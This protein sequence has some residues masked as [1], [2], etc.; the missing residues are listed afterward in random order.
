[1]GNDSLTPS[2]EQGVATHERYVR[3][4]QADHSF[5]DQLEGMPML[6][7]LS[8]AEERARMLAGQSAELAD[9]PVT[10]QRFQ[11]S[12]C[13]VYLIRPHHAPASAP[14]LFFLHGGGWVLGD[15]QT[16]TQLVC[17][18][19][20][21][22]QSVVAFVDYPRA[23]EHPYPVPLESCMSAVREVLQVA[24]KLQL[25]AERF[26]VVGDSSGGNLAA[27]L[28][29]AAIE[30]KFPLPACQ[31]LLY[32][33][34]DHNWS[35]AS[36]REY[37]E[38]PNLGLST[39]QWFWQKYLS[40]EAQ[41]AQPGASP[42]R[43]DEKLLAQCPPT[44]IVTCEYDVLRDEGEEYAARLAGAGVDVTAVRWLGSLH[45]FLVTESLAGS[46]SAQACIDTVAEYIKG[47]LEQS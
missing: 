47:R 42:L 41:G 29:L 25:N 33:V 7:N 16:H 4:S 20:V 32:P 27:A 28:V 3:L 17:E 23:P 44:M 34:T 22:T 2:S 43:A 24:G 30:Q 37:R 14:V 8:V 36:Y 21:R 35:T 11:G 5:L 12:A 31:V 45:G 18:L 13:P 9:Y 38:N 10:A 1:M 19:A 26:A 39:M 40:E 6:G 15:L 46:T